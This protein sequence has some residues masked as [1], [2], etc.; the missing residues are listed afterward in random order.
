MPPSPAPSRDTSGH[1][2]S[3]HLDDPRLVGYGGRTPYRVTLP[4]G[5]TLE[6]TFSTTV[7]YAALVR[8]GSSSPDQRARLASL[9][10]NA[11]TMPVPYDGPCQRTR[12]LMGCFGTD[13]SDP[14][15]HTE[16]EWLAMAFAVSPER[17]T[18]LLDLVTEGVWVLPRD[19][20]W[21]AYAIGTGGRGCI[22]E[23]GH[24]TRLGRPLADLV[25]R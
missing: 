18:A 22:V 3:R 2:V 12:D 5:H 21:V 20:G 15:I 17:T 11:R 6:T 8:W 19:I 14:D 4:D 24:H 13:V 23:A 1:V 10:D 16:M 9:F 25:A 7:L